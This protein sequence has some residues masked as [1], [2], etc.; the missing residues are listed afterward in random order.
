M[1]GL[2][3]FQ[4]LSMYFITILLGLL[5]QLFV[6]Y[7]LLLKFLAKVN[8]MSLFKAVIEAMMVAFGTAS[9]NATLPVTI[10]C[11]EKRAGISN[12]I[13]SFVIPLGATMNMDG[14]AVFETVAVIFLAQAYG[15]SIQDP[16]TLFGLIVIATV[17]S[18][19]AAGV[20]SG[21]MVAMT[22]ILNSVGGFSP[23]QIV[24]GITA[25]W[26][27][28][29]FVDMFRTLVNV[30]SDTV[31]ATIV[32]ASEGELDYDLLNNQDVWKDVV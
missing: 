30:T 18:I 15:V 23:E 1:V 29:R 20:P 16:Y 3:I 21:G 25:L 6:V 17:A 22:L 13:A 9:S 7:P 32:A 14:T 10:A 28:D 12:R 8:F 2:K 19:A 26:M 31:V 5:I 24:Q 11:V 4:D 27:I